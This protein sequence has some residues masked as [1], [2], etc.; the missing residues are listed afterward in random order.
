MKQ[1]IHNMFS[2]IK[3]LIMT[4]I[5]YDRDNNSLSK[6]ETTMGLELIKRVRTSLENESIDL[7]LLLGD[8]IDNGLSPKASGYLNEIKD[9][10]ERFKMPYIVVAGNHDGDIDRIHEI[11]GN[12][13]GL[14][15]INDYQI[16]TFS[17]KYNENGQSKRNID[18]MV[19]IFNNTNT[20]Q[21]T[22]VLQHNPIYPLLGEIDGYTYD[23]INCEE[24]SK[25]YSKNS[26]L[27]SLSGHYHDGIQASKKGDVDYITCP[28][29]NIE[30]FRY[31]ILTLKGSEYNIQEFCLSSEDMKR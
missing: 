6:R 21:P 20:N 9:E 30:P 27:L 16:V 12:H 14:H 2:E 28:A 19:E 15:I 13:E 17:D 29:L 4:D 18:N 26:V 11:F 23:M 8:L 24:V 3:I 31:S 25:F 5:H 22:I 7:I 10:L 1:S